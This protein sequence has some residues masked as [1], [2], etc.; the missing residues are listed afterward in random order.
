M[1]L[2]GALSTVCCEYCLLS[3]F[4]VFGWNLVGVDDA[5]VLVV[6]CISL[7]YLTFLSVFSHQVIQ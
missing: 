5:T 6:I 3:Y 4:L 2:S 7:A 1:E